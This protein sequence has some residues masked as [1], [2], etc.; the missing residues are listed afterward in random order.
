MLR[1]Q[2]NT[3]QVRLCE[4]AFASV[5][6]LNWDIRP[7]GPKSATTRRYK[8]KFHY[9]LHSYILHYLVNN[10]LYQKCAPCIKDRNVLDS[11]E[12]G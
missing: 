1:C 10:T 9:A 5:Y 8:K 3:N 7:E 4:V 12:L 2:D 6:R 11:V